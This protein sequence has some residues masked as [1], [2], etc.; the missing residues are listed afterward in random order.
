MSNRGRTLRL[1]FAL[2]LLPT[3]AVFVLVAWPGRVGQLI[4]N[5]GLA[6]IVTGL[7]NVFREVAIFRL[8][9]EES[10]E[11]IAKRVH[12]QMLESSPS[13]TGIRMIAPVRREHAAY[14]TWANVKDPQHLFFAGRT[15]L[16]SI[17][18]DFKGRGFGTAEQ[19]LARRLKEGADIRI[20][21]V[22]PRSDIVE[23][24]AMEEG[25][26]STAILKDIAKSIGICKRLYALI[27]TAELKHQSRLQIRLYEETPYFAYH[28][29][30]DKVVIG[31]YFADAPGCASPAFEVIDAEIKRIF[32]EHFKS[33]FIRAAKTTLLSVTT[34]FAPPDFNENLYQELYHHLS[35]K[36]GAEMVDQLMQQ[37]QGF[38]EEQQNA[39]LK[40]E[41]KQLSRAEESHLE[42]E[43]A[44]YEHPHPR[45]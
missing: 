12:Q 26:P 29:V 4:S 9:A 21:F 11:Q 14:F 16:K 36:L 38:K 42:Q 32:N 33:V 40:A 5:L 39:L 13:T 23:R 28:K 27:E 3:G 10:G 35:N 8:E 25:R 44:D 19:V 34:N 17:D 7:V 43:F 15:V 24:L 6:L 18:I 31:F 2:A 22:D 1:T 30:D 37:P 41:L 20:L 45:K